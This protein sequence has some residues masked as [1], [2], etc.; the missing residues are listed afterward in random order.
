MC[1]IPRSLGM[2]I[3]ATGLAT[4]WTSSHWYDVTLVAPAAPVIDSRSEYQAEISAYG[5]LRAHC[6]L[7]NRR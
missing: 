4:G 5:A 7:F 2:P 1:L 3:S 6:P